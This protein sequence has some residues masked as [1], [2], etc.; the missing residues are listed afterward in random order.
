M[1][2]R[3]KNNVQSFVLFRSCSKVLM[4][5]KFMHV[6]PF[7]L[8]WLQAMLQKALRK[9]RYFR[10]FRKCWLRSA[11]HRVFPQQLLLGHTFAIGAAAVKHLVVNDPQAP[12]VDFGRNARAAPWVVNAKALRRQVPVC[13]RALRR[14]LNVTVS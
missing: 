1:R 7:R 12:N 11:Q 13:P 5:A 4:P 9:R 6:R 10:L 2:I 3:T 14:Q 8:V